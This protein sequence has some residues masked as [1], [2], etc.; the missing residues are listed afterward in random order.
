VVKNL[1]LKVDRQKMVVEKFLK[2]SREIL[3]FSET[4]KA[5]SCTQKIMLIIKKNFDL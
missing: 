2:P 5:R 1:R 3:V 4:F